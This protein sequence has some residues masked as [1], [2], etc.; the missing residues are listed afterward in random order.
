VFCDLKYAENA[1][2]A[3]ALPQ[4][5]LWELTTLPQTPIVGWGADTPPHTP[6]HLA[7]ARTFGT[8]IIVPP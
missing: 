4:T 5:P 1:I 8:S 7:P 6:L 3:G 2:A